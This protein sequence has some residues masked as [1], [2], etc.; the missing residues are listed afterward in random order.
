MFQT[1]IRI[2]SWV[3]IASSRV[4]LLFLFSSSWENAFEFHWTVIPGR[5]GRRKGIRG[6]RGEVPLP[7]A[8][9]LRRNWL[10]RLVTMQRLPKDGSKTQN[11]V[12]P[13]LEVKTIQT[14]KT[15]GFRQERTG[16]R[17]SR[18]GGQEISHSESFS[19]V[20]SNLNLILSRFS[21]PTDYVLAS[22][23]VLLGSSCA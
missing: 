2:R 20:L 21:P 6:F 5:G 23:S 3:D 17:D 9:L 4:C 13:P 11:Q 18:K 22:R 19:A 8:N 12:T 10:R 7:C 14:R 15:H 16:K 1:C